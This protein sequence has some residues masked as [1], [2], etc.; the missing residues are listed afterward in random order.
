MRLGLS[1]L[2]GG[3]DGSKLDSTEGVDGIDVGV[4]AALVGRDGGM[5]PRA[6]AIYST[7]RLSRL[8]CEMSK[9]CNVTALER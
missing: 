5:V 1:G 7:A 9:N 2:E 8:F 4:S 3:N 6:A